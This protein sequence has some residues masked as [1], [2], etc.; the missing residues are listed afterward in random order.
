M[1]SAFIVKEHKVPGQHIREYPHALANSQNDVL[2]L[3]VKEYIPKDNQ[4]PQPG[5]VTILGAHA[6]GF[7]KE[8]YEPLWEDLHRESK[9]FGFRIR[10]IIIC[11]AAWQG[12]SSILNASKLGN[13]PGWLDYSRDINQVINHL[14]PPMP[15]VG[16]SH[17]FG[18]AALTNLAYSNPRLLTSLILLDP[19]PQQSPAAHSFRRRDVWPSR[20]DAAKSFAKSPFY[21]TW[22]PR[23][24]QAWVNHGLT[25][26]APGKSKEVTLTTT[27]HQEVFTFLRPTWT[28]FDPSGEKLVD[29][30]KAPEL[31]IE[32]NFPV[33]P[34][35]RPEPSLT[36]SRVPSI[37]PSVLY[38]LGGKS[39]LSHPPSLSNRLRTTGAGVGGSGG[40][41]YGRVRQVILPEQGHLVPMENPGD[42]ARL[43]AE[44]ISQEITRWKEGEAKEFEEWKAKSLKEK[45]VLDEE[46][47][48]RLGVPPRKPKA[49][50]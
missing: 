10:S 27:K 2:Y 9:N 47:G 39:N 5:D 28:A 37:R 6:N 14:R 32:K 1:S 21:Q 42:C 50:I 25:D 19:A 44:W 31:D 35:Y 29:R 26:I 38:V 13:D 8:L 46:W 15:I 18:G 24:L 7:P 41:L 12:Q 20:E 16:I 17:S 3:A 30:T 43:G 33:Y 48:T 22:D 49:K 11:D 40:V 36:L 4:N 45:T 23:V 34:F